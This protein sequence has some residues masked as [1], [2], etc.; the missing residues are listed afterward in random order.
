M[1]R[2]ITTLAFVCVLVAAPARAQTYVGAAI[3]ADVARSFESSTAGVGSANGNGEVINWGLRA[4][5]SL[6]SVFGV[7]VEFVRPG[8][9]DIDNP[10]FIAVPLAASFAALAPGVTIFPTP[11]IQTRQRATSWNTAAWVR[12]PLTSSADL[13]FLAGLAFSRIVEKIDYSF[14]SLP[15]GVRPVLA[16]TR[17]VAYDVGPM[18]G[19][20]A[21]V[22]L[23]EHV[24]LT[25]GLRLQSL[26]SD[27]TDGLL[28][29]PSVALGWSF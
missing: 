3:G 14:P 10:P 1:I 8:E 5:T 27:L 11:Q 24:Q 20:E 16:S 22:R 2:R 29:R 13:V 15:A 28:L 12:K 26:D 19:V 23:T 6:G 7:E 4:G 25:P 9:L 17:S 21:R 18:V